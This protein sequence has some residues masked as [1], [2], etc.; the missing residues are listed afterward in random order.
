M[1]EAGRREQLKTG[2]LVGLV[3]TSLLQVGIHW[4]RQLQWN[5]FSFAS[6][7]F[8]RS[9]VDPAVNERF[10]DARKVDYITPNRIVISDEQSGQWALDRA[11]DTWKSAWK[12]L[13]QQYLPLLA[14]EKWDKQLLRTT[15]E[16]ILAE[17][18]IVLY[19]FE[20]PIPADLLPWLT[21][22]SSER[23]TLTVS[24][25][26]P[27][28]E[29]IAMVP[30]G[31]VNNNINTLY[32]LSSDGV[33]RFSLELSANA[34]PKDWYLMDSATFATGENQLLGL[35][36]KTFNADHVRPDL[37]MAF[38]EPTVVT[39]PVYEASLPGAV[40]S[41]GFKTDNLQALQESVLLNRK[42][43]L[44]TGLDSE[45]GD[46]TFSDW[47]NTFRVDSLCEPDLS[48]LTGTWNEGNFHGRGLH[49]SRGFSGGTAKQAWK[50]GHHPL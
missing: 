23:K 10:L 16:Q 44:L 19:E 46:V 35:M 24:P 5:P 50:H 42:D 32:V 7:F 6:G 40:P 26:I 12:D 41:G 28:I 49:P 30:K 29:K 18:R 39:M 34:L 37:L 47:E 22:P 21:T 15:W 3:L 2:L 33:Y 48:V 4:S 9:A 27:D 31:S 20:R 45:T 36:G 11:G 43:S 14:T 25:S 17:N 1:I 13:K 8:H 38:D